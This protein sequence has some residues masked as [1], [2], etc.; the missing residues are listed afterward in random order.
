MCRL[1]NW[2]DSEAT[3]RRRESGGASGGSLNNLIDAIDREMAD[4]AA[5]SLLYLCWSVWNRVERNELDGRV[6]SACVVDRLIE[7]AERIGACSPEGASPPRRTMQ[8]QL[9]K[10]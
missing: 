4:P 5:G 9:N 7:R 10:S 3:A 1:I 8:Q 2:E 6:G